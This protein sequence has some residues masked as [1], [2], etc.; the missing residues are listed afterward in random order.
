MVFN[1]LLIILYHQIKNRDS[2]NLYSKEFV[3]FVQ[4]N[5]VLST[6]F[7]L[8]L[9][10]NQVLYSFNLLLTAIIYLAMIYVSGRKGYHFV[11]STMMVYGAYQ[12]IE[13]S[14][15]D[16]FG[17]IIYAFIGFGMVVVPKVMKRNFSLDNAFQYTS[18]VISGFA[19]VYISF[20][21][22]LLRA[23]N[24]SIVLMLAYFIISA[25][26]VY[27]SYNGPMRLF[28]YLGSIFLVSA[29]YEAMSLVIEPF[30]NI[31]FTLSFFISGF[32][33]LL[34][35]ESCGFQNTLKSSNRAQKSWEL[36]LW[37]SES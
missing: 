33:Y 32:I 35:L 18:A 6:L 13:N 10:D 21:G 2:F 29:I 37:Q 15:L 4:V 3:P 17:A 20:E 22:I 23:G 19:F 14:F 25:N 24:P 28:P 12:L 27:L 26:F 16:S 11:F 5:L 1:G 34:C 7:M 8:F 9:Y 30:K 31:H 36:P